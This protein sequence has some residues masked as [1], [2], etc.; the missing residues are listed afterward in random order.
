MDKEKTTD[1]KIHWLTPF[2]NKRKMGKR[3][4]TDSKIHW[5]TPFFRL[6]WQHFSGCFLWN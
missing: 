6:H 1:S 3:K 4:T 5:L 2:W